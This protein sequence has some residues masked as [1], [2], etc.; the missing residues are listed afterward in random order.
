MPIALATEQTEPAKAAFGPEEERG[1]VSLL[2]DFPE[3][4]APASNFLT[5]DIFSSL[6]A[7]FVIA[8]LHTDFEKHGVVP[9]RKLLKDRLAKQLNVDDPWESIL[10]LVD[11]PTNVREAPFLRDILF[12]WAEHQTLALLY[13]EEAIEAYH[14]GNYD[15]LKSIVDKAERLK[16]VGV[17]GFWLYDQVDELF[18]DN[19][20]EHISTGFT[21]LDKHLNSGGPSKQEVLMW[22]APTGVGKSLLLCNNA[23]TCSRN[24][25]NVL[26]VTFELSKEKTGMRMLGAMSGIPLD[27]FIVHDLAT[28]PADELV[29]IRETQ[30]RL[31]QQAQRYKKRGDIVIYQLPPDECSVEHIYSI[32]DTNEKMNGWK[33]DVVVLDYLDL[34]MSRNSSMNDSSYDR[35]KSVSTEVRGLARN[36]DVLVYTATQTNRSGAKDDN[37]GGGPN[38]EAAGPG[39]IGLD[40]MAESFGKSMPVDYVISL[41]QTEAEYNAARLNPGHPA[42]IRFWIAK[43]RNGAKAQSITTNVWYDRMQIKEIG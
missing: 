34:M 15:Y 5:P 14:T 40:K 18:V 28:T 8:Q 4:Y 27:Q 20:I 12:K 2:I 31:R 22:L 1:I 19:A 3:L 35:Q 17:A 42:T 23:F 13:Q 25:L 21:T 11:R 6:E 33:P 24:G 9:S 39:Q 7:K 38:Q 26:F 43:N 32:I 16:H 37:R 36:A 41:N 29:K 10:E 30:G